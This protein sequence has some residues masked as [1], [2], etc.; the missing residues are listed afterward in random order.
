MILYQGELVGAGGYRQALLTGGSNYSTGGQILIVDKDVSV[1]AVTSW[2]LWVVGGALVIV[3]AFFD[4]WFTGV[5]LYT[6]GVGGVL[7]IRHMLCRDSERRHEAFE[8]GREWERAV[9]PVRS[10]R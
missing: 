3:G 7:S 1:T 10:L 5:G 2:F 8:M 6:A 4:L 9:S